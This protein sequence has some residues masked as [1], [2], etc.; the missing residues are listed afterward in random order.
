LE[1]GNS[2]ERTLLANLLNLRGFDYL[3]L[4]YEHDK[5]TNRG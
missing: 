2:L 5:P 3:S 4:S 1:S